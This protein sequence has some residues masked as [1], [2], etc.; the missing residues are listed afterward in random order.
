MITHK[1][2]Q[3]IL[4]SINR[5]QSLAVL[6]AINQA[7]ADRVR[8]PQTSERRSLEIAKEALINARDA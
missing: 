3:E 4:L 1:P 5:A 2:K 6:R 8:W 7:L